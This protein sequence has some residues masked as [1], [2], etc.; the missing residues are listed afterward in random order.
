MTR[1]IKVLP[2]I[3]GAVAGAV[4]AL[5]IA[6]GGTT[7]TVI[8]P[9]ASA[10]NNSVPT[11]ISKTTSG[12]SVNQI[13]KTDSPGVVDIVVNVGATGLQQRL[14]QHAFADDRGRGSRR[15]L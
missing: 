15:R 1:L 2:V 12:L 11:A 6:N 9:F 14:L 13:Y 4:V 10:S 5:L 8:E 3:A 7:K